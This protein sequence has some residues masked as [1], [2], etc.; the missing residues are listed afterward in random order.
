MKIQLNSIFVSNVNILKP[1]GGWDGLGAA[2]YTLLKEDIE[3]LALCDTI[4]PPGPPKYTRIGNALMGI[5]LHQKKFLFFSDSRLQN[6][7]NQ[8]RHKLSGNNDL[9]L[10]HGSTPWVK[11]EPQSK[12]VVFTDCSFAT[13]LSV[14]HD[15]RRFSKTD[16]A[17]IT[18]LD[19]NFLKN[20][21]LVFTTSQWAANA[22]I[23]DYALR[24]EKVVVCGQ[25]PSIV[26]RDR[27]NKIERVIV[28]RF[29]FIA[30]D[31]HGKGGAI[32]YSALLEFVKEF[33]DYKLTIVGARPPEEIVS[34]E[35]VDYLGFVDKSTNAGLEIM[36]NLYATS[37]AILLLT[38]KDAAP[39]VLVE[40]AYFG[41]PAIAN[42]FSAIPELIQDRFNGYLVDLN[43][44]SLLESFYRIARLNDSDYHTMRTNALNVVKQ[45]FNWDI[46]KSRILKAIA[47]I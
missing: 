42:N 16:I 33:P 15:T 28:N 7:A 38:T 22:M 35:F 25:G 6:V 4:N 14:Y 5:L 46:V 20:A 40:A 31:F 36:E 8:L 32:I 18:A 17:H 2:I 26:P 12:Y 1:K 27:F 21:A 34:N 30:S 29:L 37:K 23:V 13:Y 47:N 11:V 24:P 9:I 45:K 3:V 39:L 10:F 41:C 43:K 19:R 44:E